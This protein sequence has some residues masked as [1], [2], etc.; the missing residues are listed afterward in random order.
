MKI[1]TN[2]KRIE[3]S[4]Q[5]AK[6]AGIAAMVILAGGLYLSIRFQDQVWVSLGALII[7]FVLSQV[8]ISLTNRFGRTDRT[9]Q[10]LDEALKGLDDRYAIYHY[11]GPVPHML[12]GPAGIY[13]L[14]PYQ[15]NGKITYNEEKEEWKRK[16]GNLYLR[17][18]AQDTIGKPSLDVEIAR[19]KV[20]N[21]MEQIPDFEVPPVDAALIFTH[22]DA[23]VEAENAPQPTLHALTLKK[24]IRK[25]EK[26]P[27]SIS[28]TTVRT[29]QDSLEHGG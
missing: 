14:L 10:V 23:E 24:F 11:T 17:I 7:G 8:S 13:A 19:E 6:Y 12:V 25:Q 27:D 16:G 20:E 18:F 2:Q 29:V 26:S 28:M 5:I 4:Q 3:R 21:H 15:N 9:D 22:P 1:H